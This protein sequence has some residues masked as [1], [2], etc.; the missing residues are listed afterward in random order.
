MLCGSNLLQFVIVD[1]FGFP[2]HAVRNDLVGLAR[3]IQMMSV[4]EMAAMSKVQTKNRVTGLEHRSVGSL[5]S[6][7]SR[8]RLYVGVLRAKKFLGPLTRKFFHYVG[9]L[10]SAVVALARIALRI[11]V[12]EDRSCGL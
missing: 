9:E 3:K 11:L 2:G 12:G 4:G 8:V 5:I 6:L 10:A 7:R 1:G